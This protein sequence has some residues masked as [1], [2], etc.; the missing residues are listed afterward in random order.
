MSFEQFDALVFELVTVMQF[1]ILVPMV[2]VWA[3]R[4]NFS[5]PVK[6]LS[7]YVYISAFF[8][9][10]ARLSAIYLHNNLLFLIGFNVAKV[11]LLVAVYRLVLTAPRTRRLLAIA[12][13]AGLGIVAASFV[14][15]LPRAVT[16]SRVVQCALLAG[17][18]LAYLE[19]GL[20]RT[21]NRRFNGDPIW[22]LSVGQLIY[23]AA[24]VSTFSIEIVTLFKGSI[25][26]TFSALSFSLASLVFNYFLT[27]AFLRATPGVPP[28]L[29]APNVESRLVAS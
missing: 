23:S 19:Q 1:S 14:L 11:L 22:L 7:L 18:A 17:F 20:N 2:V 15:G 13:L 9:L 4:R 21:D 16:V 12:T 27:L 3:R 24:T 25:F 8:A 5:P 29:V 6:V 28:R 26:N 10:S